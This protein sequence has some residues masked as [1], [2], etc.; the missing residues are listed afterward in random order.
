MG[1]MEIGRYSNV[2][3]RI[4]CLFS[5]EC[6]FIIILYPPLPPGTVLELF[7]IIFLFAFKPS[8]SDDVAIRPLCRRSVFLVSSCIGFQPCVG[9]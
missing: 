6:K 9:R 8:P 1:I 4:F 7:L 5:S 3:E 2:G